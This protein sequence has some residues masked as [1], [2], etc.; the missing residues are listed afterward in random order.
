[1]LL[2][3]LQC[4]GVWGSPAK[5]KGPALLPLQEDVPRQRHLSSPMSSLDSSPLLLLPAAAFLQMGWFHLLLSLFVSSST[6]KYSVLF[7]LAHGRCS[8]SLKASV[9]FASDHPVLLRLCSPGAQALCHGH[10]FAYRHICAAMRPWL[11]SGGCGGDEASQEPSSCPVPVVG[12][13]LMLKPWG[14]D[15]LL[16]KIVEQLQP[17]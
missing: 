13:S 15:F 10:N 2:L 16:L 4:W 12:G 9:C 3:D 8:G 14:A 5:A 17:A 1:M 7:C 11:G 6:L